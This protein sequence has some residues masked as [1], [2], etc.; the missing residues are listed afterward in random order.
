[1]KVINGERVVRGGV[2]LGTDLDIMGEHFSINMY[3]L[4]LDGF[5][6]IL[7]VQWLHAFCPILWN[8]T[9]LSMSF[10]RYG[11]TVFWPGVGS[12]IIWAVPT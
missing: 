1:V 12:P 4:S 3:V 11:H 6:I 10:W 7:G 5:D 2:C 8:F 9:N